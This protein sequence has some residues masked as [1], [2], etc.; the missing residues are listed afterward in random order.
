MLDGPT[1][2]FARNVARVLSYSDFE[3]TRAED[4]NKRGREFAEFLLKNESLI[5]KVLTQY[6]TFE[7]ASD[8]IRRCVDLFSSLSEN[9][10]YFT[11]K[12]ANATVVFMPR[13]QPLYAL[14]CFGFVPSFQSHIVNVRPPLSMH[15]FFLELIELLQIENFFPN[16]Q[17]SFEQR[18]I[19]VEKHARVISDSHNLKNPITDVVIFTGTMENADQMRQK[20]SPKTL[21]IANGAGHN[22]VIISDDA[23]LAAAA[24][25]VA[26]LQ[27]Y[28][29]GQDCANPSAV[30][31]KRSVVKSFINELKK[32]LKLAPIGP[33][34]NYKNR[35]GPL[36]EVKDL[37]R[38][39]SLLVDN[40]SYIDPETPGIISAYDRIV[41]PTIIQKPLIDGPNFTEQF[42]PIFFIQ[43]YAQDSD[44][45]IYFDDPR[46]EKNAMYVTLFGSSEYVSKLPQKKFDCGRF[47]HPSSTIILNTDLHAPG[48]ERGTQPYGGYGRGASCVSYLNRIESKPT[49]PQR[50][51]ANFLQLRNEAKSGKRA[52]AAIAFKSYN[53]KVLS[54]SGKSIAWWED[55]AANLSLVTDK[56]RY[57]I[58]IDP[59]G[60]GQLSYARAIFTLNALLKA[61]KSEDSVHIVWNDLQVLNAD[62]TIDLSMFNSKPINKIPDLF[63]V[64]D[65]AFMKIES[66]F[67][68][69]IKT[70]DLATKSH[71][72]SG[73][74]TQPVFVEKIAS[75]LSKQNSSLQANANIDWDEILV[76]RSRFTG[77]ASTRIIHYDSQH[78]KIHYECLER[79]KI[80]VID[81]YEDVG[82][83]SLRP[84]YEIAV[85]AEFLEINVIGT[86]RNDS[87]EKL[88]DAAANIHFANYGTDIF[89]IPVGFVGAQGR[90]KDFWWV[91]DYPL[92]ECLKMYEVQVLQWLFASSE[93]QQRVNLAFHA[94]MLDILKSFENFRVSKI[95]NDMKIK[96]FFEIGKSS[97]SEIKTSELFMLGELS[98]WNFTKV[99]SH[100][101]VEQ[102]PFE[103]ESLKISFACLRH[104][105]LENNF[106]QWPFLKEKNLNY[107]NEMSEA[108]QKNMKQIASMLSMLSK[109][110]Q[111]EIQSSVFDLK[112]SFPSETGEH[113]FKDFYHLVFGVP[114][115]PK[116][117]KL[118]ALGN[119]DSIRRL[120]D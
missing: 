78:Q 101:L 104:W 43:E 18:E 39:Q 2:V 74:Y 19:F 29:Q 75:F 88:I 93:L 60:F 86:L 7:V 6:E 81:L 96:D 33:Y 53:P 21:F 52:K 15:L 26:S 40:A 20:F 113:L 63:G 103:Q 41:H 34:S 46:Y 67:L 85:V 1:K 99:A 89:A 11:G 45:S 82:F 118:I 27:L 22:P 17:I 65:S 28:N 4:V 109:K 100:L 48:V 54:P 97:N 80:D 116:I 49:C 16:V 84:K 5:A 111:K 73:F 38:V 30:L 62:K 36:T 87:S 25:S 44:L 90:Q 108:R 13:N 35:V 95:E 92:S 51:I 117:S 77:K 107:W 32:E 50:D 119:L 112:K 31:V 115:G 64:H 24:K 23:N 106:Q 105:T 55:L 12:K 72:V 91:S 66:D 120:L 3:N 68:S 10:D 57:A 8:E 56:P 59:V 69:A 9:K 47:L 83:F 102:V 58:F 114:N 61:K 94:E 71:S 98:E 76:V 110:P 14:S 70:F 37:K 79:G 42:A